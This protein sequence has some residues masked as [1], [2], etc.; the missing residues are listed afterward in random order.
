LLSD[1]ICR[2]LVI[3]GS[4]PMAGRSLTGY[5]LTRLRTDSSARPSRTGPVSRSTIR[6]ARPHPVSLMSVPPSD[7][8][9][10]AAYSR[11][12]QKERA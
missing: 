9:L 4:R 5:R 7:N 11:L 2:R 10:S 3:A 8:V 6:N 12:L 1:H